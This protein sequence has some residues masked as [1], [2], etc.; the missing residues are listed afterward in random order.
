MDI[1]KNVL[2]STRRPHRRT[3]MNLFWN[4]KLE[5]HLFHQCF[6]P[7]TQP[8]KLGWEWNHPRSRYLPS[9]PIVRSTISFHIFFKSCGPMSDLWNHYGPQAPSFSCLV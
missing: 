3:I 7:L 6:T 2:L 8:L 5:L 4:L 9:T 1:I